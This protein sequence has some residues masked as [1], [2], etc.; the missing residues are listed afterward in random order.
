[1]RHDAPFTG[2]IA[3]AC[4]ALGACTG[5]PPRITGKDAPGFP[6]AS[7]AVL[8]DPH[9]FDTS[10]GTPGPAGERNLRSG[11]KLLEE[12]A[13]ILAQG[14]AEISETRP[15]FLI[16]PG[17]LTK[18][19]E[20]ESHAAMAKA[21]GEIEGSGIPVFVVPGNHDVLNPHAARY[22]GDAVE[23]AETVTPVDFTRI[24]SAFGYG[25]AVF[26]DPASL[27]YV[28]E[29]VRGLWLIGI[30]SCRYGEGGSGPV[31]EGR[32]RQETYTWLDGVLREARARGM[33]VIAF[34]H[35]GA[36][37]HFQ[38]QDS[39][40]G[41]YVIEG[42]D[43][44][45]R[46]LA[47]GGVRTVFTGHGHAQDITVQR[48]EDGSFLFDIQTGSLSSWP[49]PYRIV[50]ISAGGL[51][52]IESR[53]IR[54]FPGARADFPAYSK[55]RLRQGLRSSALYVLRRLLVEEK[56]ARL[57]AEQGVEAGV[58]FYGGDEPGRKP[59]LDMSGLDWWAGFI[60]GWLGAPLSYLGTDLMPVD[61][62]IAID[63]TDGSWRQD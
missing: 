22:V 47:Q 62:D 32:L 3:L 2:F 12:S 31:T 37:E 13:A 25:E 20:K 7:F 54:G 63:M 48:F 50:R 19:G 17:D 14:L 23:K 35:H 21:L 55:L 42:H 51:M 60:A 15:Q 44:V 10:T 16:V 33:S 27:S 6:A 45:S 11:I 41:Q 53:F 1:M 43:A 38:D 49:D 56:S 59:A 26:R 24:Y 18:D 30:D 28:S 58:D 61:N 4:L 29:P 52:R 34:M 36:M 8:S 40:L 5:I 9:L 39:F 46:L 57:I